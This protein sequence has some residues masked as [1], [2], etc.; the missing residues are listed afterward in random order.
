MI[1]TTKTCTRCGITKPSTDFR[2]M[3]NRHGNPMLRSRCREC[4]QLIKRESD[5]VRHSAATLKHA[6]CDDCE[7]ASHCKATGATCKAFDLFVETGQV[8]F[9]K[10]WRMPHRLQVAA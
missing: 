5:A 8:N 1:P 3:I 7:H 10:R 2:V 9:A 4:M 6:P